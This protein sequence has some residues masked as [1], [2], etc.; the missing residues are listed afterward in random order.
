MIQRFKD[1]IHYH[2]R[3]VQYC[4]TRTE[5]RILK[6]P[7]KSRLMGCGNR[8]HFNYSCKTNP[9]QNW[10]YFLLGSPM[11][12][13]QDDQREEEKKNEDEFLKSFVFNLDNHVS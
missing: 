9:S 7:H 12:K 1:L 13:S 5:W 3:I 2:Y 10:L 4:A 11:I 6:T 8:A